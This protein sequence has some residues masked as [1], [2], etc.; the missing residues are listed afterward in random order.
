MTLTTSTDPPDPSSDDPDFVVHNELEL[1]WCDSPSVNRCFNTDERRCVIR[2]LSESSSSPHQARLCQIQPSKASVKRCVTGWIT[3]RSSAPH[4]HV[5]HGGR[6]A[7]TSS[8]SAGGHLDP[9]Q[10][11]AVRPDVLTGF[12][13]I[14]WIQTKLMV[15]DIIS[16]PAV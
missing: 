14:R 6:C 2:H 5:N 15:R 9:E 7:S 4:H 12:W 1:V 10:V 16:T 11:S 13:S 3:F 8:R